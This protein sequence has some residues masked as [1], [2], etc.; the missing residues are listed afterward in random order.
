MEEEVYGVYR[1]DPPHVF[2]PNAIY[3]VTGSTLGSRK[4]MRTPERKQ[5]FVETLF[6]SAET[7]GWRL[8]AWA[9]L[10]NHY[11]FIARA[12]ESG[13]TL[14][15]LVQDIHSITGKRFNQ[16]DGISGRQVWYTCWDSLLQSEKEYW[17]GLLYVHTNPVRHR[18]VARADEYPFCSYS[19]FKERAEPGFVQAVL[20]QQIEGY[21]LRE[22][23]GDIEV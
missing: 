22:G 13:S 11:H 12:P 19:W 1:H 2:R 18:M 9:V 17:E 14:T 23:I 8:E 7:L 5:F 6:E 16:E 4:P 10:P 21:V 3:M 20:S 15:A